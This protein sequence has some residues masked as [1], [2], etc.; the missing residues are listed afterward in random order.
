MNSTRKQ[1]T[2]QGS[3]ANDSYSLLFFK[4]LFFLRE[5]E[6]RERMSSGEGQRETERSRLLTEQGAQCGT[7][8]QDPEPKA[9]AQLTK[10]PRHPSSYFLYHL[11]SIEYWSS[12][13][14]SEIF[15]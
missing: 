14:L 9:D 13:I 11:T 2:T 6:R 12:F 4:I 7:P 10:P 1:K 3:F 15:L 5:R 8:S